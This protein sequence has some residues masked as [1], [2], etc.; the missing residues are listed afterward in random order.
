MSLVKVHQLR[1]ALQVHFE[2]VSL[3]EGV[4]SESKGLA[5][6]FAQCN[7]NAPKDLY[8]SLFFANFATTIHYYTPRSV[9]FM[10]TLKSDI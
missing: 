4:S 7:G 1:R 2:G 3:G 5:V 9:V 8:F 6:D 10:R